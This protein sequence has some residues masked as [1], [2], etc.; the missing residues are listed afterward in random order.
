MS[1]TQKAIFKVIRFYDPNNKDQHLSSYY[2]G[3][4]NGK[5]MT[6]LDYITRNQACIKKALPE[7][8]MQVLEELEEARLGHRIGLVR[9]W[10][11]KYGAS[12]K[13]LKEVMKI[14]DDRYNVWSDWNDRWE[15][16]N[17]RYGWNFKKKYF[18]NIKRWIDPKDDTLSKELKEKLWNEIKEFEKYEAKKHRV[19]EEFL[20]QK[21]GT[22]I[23]TNDAA[24]KSKGSF[25][26]GEMSKKEF[27]SKKQE[28]LAM[29]KDDRLMWDTTLSF[30]KKFAE[31]NKLLTPEVI[32]KLIEKHIDQFFKENHLDPSRMFWGFSMH[33]NTNNPHVHLFFQEHTQKNGEWRLKG[34]LTEES[35]SA[36]YQ[37]VA[38][39]AQINTLYL[40]QMKSIQYETTKL[41]TEPIA[42]KFILSNDEKWSIHRDIVKMNEL[43]VEVQNFKLK[44]ENLLLFEPAKN[45][46]TLETLQNQLESSQNNFNEAKENILLK[47]SVENLKLYFSTRVSLNF[48]ETKIFEELSTYF[49]NDGTWNI[50]R[51]IQKISKLEIEIQNLKLEI[52]NLLISG[53]IEGDKILET[54]QKQL[55]S[56]Q[57]NFNESKEKV[58]KLKTIDFA[59]NLT[60]VNSLEWDQLRKKMVKG[61]EQENKNYF[62]WY[63]KMQNFLLP[64]QKYLRY[65]NLTDE[66]KKIAIKYIE[67]MLLKNPE[68]QNLWEKEKENI[69]LYTKE[70]FK[71]SFYNI[72]KKQTMKMQNLQ[73]LDN[74]D[75]V[76][77]QIDT[78]K[79]YNSEINIDNVTKEQ[80]NKLIQKEINNALWENNGF[81]YAKQANVLFGEIQNQKEQ[82][83]KKN[84]H[85]KKFNLNKAMNIANKAINNIFSFGSN[86]AAAEFEKEMDKIRKRFENNLEQYER[87]KRIALE[88]ERMMR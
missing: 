80:R 76:G 65:E 3:T 79:L 45:N 58:S 9:E 82:L 24:W 26:F 25:K 49:L 28:F 47:H 81:F 7:K 77:V 20:K 86:K 55:E 4:K 39:N 61:H 38:L 66:G 78:T 73:I 36:F 72:G 37:R 29:K 64:D 85:S 63:D 18:D 1:E 84:K 42:G 30:D 35:M 5:N 14:I 8:A 40:Q 71:A 88:Q 15:T 10:R 23:Y 11:Q 21:W 57:N 31:Q 33:G 50:Y 75:K 43:E 74:L 34:E 12:E 83:D 70:L 16:V 13:Y 67:E 62:Q 46:K 59:A 87:A 48:N 32:G 27:L 60:K 52:E 17:K 54:L 51:D 69:D 53:S 68:T 2:R 56:S 19:Y 41:L 6:Y 22:G 44:I